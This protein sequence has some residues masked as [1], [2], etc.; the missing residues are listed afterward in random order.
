MLVYVYG[1][2]SVGVHVFVSAFVC[3]GICVCVHMASHVF[4]SVYVCIGMIYVM[5]VW[6]VTRL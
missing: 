4:V 1:S 5:R 6:V 3:M 2:A